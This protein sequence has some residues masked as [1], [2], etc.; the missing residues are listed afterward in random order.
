MLNKRFILTALSQIN[1]L[2]T[3][4]KFP[5]ILFFNFQNILISCIQMS[6]QKNPQY[7]ILTTFCNSLGCLYHIMIF[8]SFFNHFTSLPW[9]LLFIIS[10]KSQI[11]FRFSHWFS[12]K[13]KKQL[14]PLKGEFCLKRNFKTEE[15]CVWMDKN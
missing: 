13:F 10:W 6:S 5:L 7:I 15:G 4:A 11:Q 14:S 8:T 2:K 12:F 3:G 9:Q 1:Q